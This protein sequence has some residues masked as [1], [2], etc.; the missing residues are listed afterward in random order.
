ML[1]NFA[2][3]NGGG[4]SNMGGTAVLTACNISGNFVGATGTGNALAGGGIYNGEPGSIELKDCH[5]LPRFMSTAN[6]H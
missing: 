6:E 1:G 3:G 2:T 4:L 5:L